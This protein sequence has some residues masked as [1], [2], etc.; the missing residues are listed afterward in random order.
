MAYNDIG[1]LLTGDSNGNII[2][3]QKSTNRSTRT[4]YNAHDGGVFTICAMKDGTIVTGG[5]KD[6]RIVE[7]DS[8]LNKTGREAK[9]RIKTILLK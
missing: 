2:V 6:R 3:W 9:V 5:G 1:E 4:V 8:N 7:W